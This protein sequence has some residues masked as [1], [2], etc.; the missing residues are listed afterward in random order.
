MT[1]TADAEND[2]ET[3]KEELT[4]IG[5]KNG[6]EAVQDCEIR[7]T[8]EWTEFLAGTGQESM[9]AL[10]DALRREASKTEQHARQYSSSIFC[11]G[12]FRGLE[13]PKVREAQDAYD[14]GVQT[15]IEEGF[16]DRMDELLTYQ[17]EFQD[18]TKVQYETDASIVFVRI[19]DGAG[20]ETVESIFSV[21]FDE[22]EPDYDY[23]EI[24]RLVDFTGEKP[25]YDDV[26]EQTEEKGKATI[27]FPFTDPAR[28]DDFADKAARIAAD[29]TGD[30]IGKDN[31]GDFVAFA[32]HEPEMIL[33][34][35]T[36]RLIR[37]TGVNRRLAR[38]AVEGEESF[39]VQSTEVTLMETHSG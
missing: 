23:E 22:Y 4:E 33:S 31:P 7:Q 19:K 12:I 27:I 37:E 34:L 11:Q 6:V 36:I 38:A 13:G 15:G 35:S 3:F 1:I 32:K 14:E 30:E 25:L 8:D 5:F 16:G 29:L 20:P 17:L 2:F 21:I 24:E 18:L 26:L 28:A 10:K 39:Q 9:D